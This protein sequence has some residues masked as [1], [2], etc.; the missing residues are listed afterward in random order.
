[1][2]TIVCKWADRNEHEKM[3]VAKA[4]CRLWGNSFLYE[5]LWLRKY[6]VIKIKIYRNVYE[7]TRVERLYFN[8]RLASKTVTRK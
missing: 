3:R 5:A 2:E 7:M 8:L 1:M 4:A 6:D